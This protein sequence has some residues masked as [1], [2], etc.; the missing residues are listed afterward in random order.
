MKGKVAIRNKNDI[1]SFK[2][3]YE[4]ENVRILISHCSYLCNS[5][6]FEMNI[7]VI[8]ECYICGKANVL[9]LDNKTS[10]SELKEEL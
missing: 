2:A 6:V 3:S 7:K 8:K 10:Q 5:S 4:I 9:F 1:C